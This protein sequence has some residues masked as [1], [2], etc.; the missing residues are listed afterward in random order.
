M[1]RD[2]SCF[3]IR[4]TWIFCRTHTNR[5]ESEESQIQICRSSVPPVTL[6]YFDILIWRPICCPVHLSTEPFSQS[7]PTDS[8][9]NLNITLSD[10][11]NYSTVCC[12]YCVH[13]LYRSGNTLCFFSGFQKYKSKN[14]E[15]IRI[16]SLCNSCTCRIVHLIVKSAEPM[17]HKLHQLEVVI[18]SDKLIKLLSCGTRTSFLNREFFMLP[19]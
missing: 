5:G 9:T 12:V 1:Q 18:K 19:G 11:M 17:F 16:I 8:P 4:L 14:R 10:R 3:W 15:N 13:Q 6:M 7:N 2:R